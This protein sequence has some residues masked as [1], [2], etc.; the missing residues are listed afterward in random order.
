MRTSILGSLCLALFAAA[1]GPAPAAGDG[2]ADA[3]PPCTDCND[4]INLHCTS[5]GGEESAAACNT[6]LGTLEMGASFF[7]GDRRRCYPNPNNPMCQ[8][9]CALSAMSFTNMGNMTSPMYCGFDAMN[10]GCKIN[11]ST[12]YTVVVQNAAGRR[13]T[14]GVGNDGVCPGV[15]GERRRWALVGLEDLRTAARC[16]AATPASGFDAPTQF[17]ACDNNEAA[18]T[19]ESRTTC[20]ELPFMAGMRMYNRSICAKPCGATPECGTNGLCI[21]G[22]CF[23]RCGGP[24]ALGCP[25][26]FTCS[27][28]VCLPTPL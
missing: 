20:T 17:V 23:H 19:P 9:L 4:A 12:G 22:N 7:V 8:P 6:R 21:D 14:V 15:P 27:D 5:A 25:D 24:C 16:A 2:G 3:G 26:S 13:A 11:E 18:C 1:C 28:G 10:P